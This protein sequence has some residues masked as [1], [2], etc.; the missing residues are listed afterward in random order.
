MDAITLL[1]EQHAELAAAFEA[2]GVAEEAVRRQRFDE[3]ADLL[4]VHTAVEEQ[5]FYP[6]CHRDSTE[7]MLYDSLAE[8]LHA[9]RLLAE[10]LDEPLDEA[11][12]ERLA[13]LRAAVLE[14]AEA[15]ES[16][17]LPR[18]AR[19]LSAERR[20]EL[21][22]AMVALAARLRAGHPRGNLASQVDSLPALE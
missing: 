21:G 17:L 15:E 13:A 9:R 7:A 1:V 8:H 11:W 3:L 4:L 10:L 19:L 6:A 2:V 12:D 20:E 14:H 16:L 5:I 22:S 18:V